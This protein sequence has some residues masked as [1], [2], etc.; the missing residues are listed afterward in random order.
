MPEVTIYTALGWTIVFAGGIVAYQYY[1]GGVNKRGARELAQKVKQNLPAATATDTRPAKAQ[2]KDSKR[3]AV[4][5]KQSDA[6]SKTAEKKAD[7]TGAQESPSVRSSAVEKDT[8]DTA[9]AYAL[10]QRR[11]GVSTKSTKADSKRE[12]TVK[13]S[14]ANKRAELSATSSTVA[15]AEDNTSPVLSPQ[16]QNDMPSGRDVSDMLEAPQ[17]GPSVLRLT[18]PEFQ[19]P[20]RQPKQQKPVQE[21]ESKKARQNRKKKEEAA[22]VRQEQEQ[23]R[24]VLM[25][26][27]MRTAR[28]SRGEPAKNGVPVAVQP[29]NVWPN[30]QQAVPVT[31][32]VVPDAPLLD[33]FSAD[34]VS[35]SSSAAPATPASASI[36][37]ANGIQYTLPD[38]DEQMRQLIEQDDSA[39]TSVPSKKSK[40]AG[41]ETTQR[42]AVQPT[43][44]TGK[45]SNIVNNNSLLQHLR[46]DVEA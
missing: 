32:S 31:A 38:E 25:E 39:W 46:D 10:A 11:T 44:A 14:D 34:N 18:E 30:G 27:Q 9:F 16:P 22:R 36:N 29:N 24:R 12:K 45:K 37:G 43:A 6:P 41:E 3:P 4:K 23:E 5:H 42:G 19:K 2:R 40:K 20:A 33:T 28:E 21:A 7:T 8:D 26:K 13:Q 1:N 17:A 15:D 35:T